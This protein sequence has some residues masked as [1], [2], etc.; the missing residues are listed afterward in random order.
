MTLNRKDVHR[1]GKTLER[2]NDG[3]VDYI[4]DGYIDDG[5][6]DRIPCKIGYTLYTFYMDDGGDHIEAT[7][8]FVTSDGVTKSGINYSKCTYKLV[9]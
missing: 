3:L 9:Y 6:G 5:Y 4:T 2:I 8:I 7:H 1:T